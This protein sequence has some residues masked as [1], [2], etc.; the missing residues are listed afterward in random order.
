ME[1]TF[2]EAG[3]DELPSPVDAK[4][5]TYQA[6]RR[7]VI[8]T[9]SMP[10]GK[11]YSQA[12]RQS[13][14]THTEY[15]A[16]IE[17]V[18]IADNAEKPTR[19]MS[20]AIYARYCG[21]AKDAISKRNQVLSGS[22]ET[23]TDYEASLVIS[24][25]VNSHFWMKQ[26]GKTSEMDTDI[27]A[28]L[29]T[30]TLTSC[31]LQ[32]LPHLRVIERDDNLHEIRDRDPDAWYFS[33]DSASWFIRPARPEL[34]DNQASEFQFVRISSGVG[35]EYR[36]IEY[37]EIMNTVSGSNIKRNSPFCK[38]FDKG[39]EHYANRIKLFFKYLNSEYGSRL[40]ISRVERFIFNKL[41]RH[42]DSDIVAA[43]LI[44]GRNH[45][46]SGSGLHYTRISAFDL[47]R[48]YR[49]T[50]AEIAARVKEHGSHIIPMKEGKLQSTEAAG[51]GLHIGSRMVPELDDITAL[52]RKLQSELANSRNMPRGL[53]RIIEVHNRMTLYTVF[54]LSFATGYRAV[55]D[56]LFEETEMDEA[57]GFA[58]LSDK[59]G[60]ELRRGEYRR[61]YY[62][63][64]IVWLP[65][66]CRTQI[67][68]YRRHLAVFKNLAP[69]VNVKLYH[70][71]AGKVDSG[72]RSD[73][74]PETFII[75]PNRAF[76]Q[77]SPGLLARQVSDVYSLPMNAHR[78]YLR[79]T[80]FERGCNVDVINAFMGH[81]HI[82]QE[83]WGRY[84]GMSPIDY[85]N[86]L[87]RHL[88][89]MMQELGWKPMSGLSK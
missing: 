87:A 59:E 13:G 33:M 26:C 32:S 20:A 86:E 12:L 34:A 76:E 68:H 42:Q 18:E 22:Y 83:P 54:M 10:V 15:A 25:L 41:A 9:M 85:R 64:R 62:N 8:R 2:D 65:E 70:R 40:S 27:K 30:L 81:S 84:S 56:P 60:E 55:V 74:F 43:S 57:S 50:W 47:N 24:G 37:F 82:G 38:P 29:M 35:L 77:V 53:P 17:I 28:A 89:E 73:S 21:N 61:T 14:A 23:L 6:Q 80:L 48:I 67:R 36:L 3:G 79:S 78:H 46:L 88:P 16:N 71:L 66:S 31:E 75:Q 39:L 45:V 49:E 52:V 5:K 4:K 63:T 1:A 72:R 19:G 7:Q 44:T 58:M 69:E 11:K 51:T